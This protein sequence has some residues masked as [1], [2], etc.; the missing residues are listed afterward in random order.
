MRAVAVALGAILVCLLSC[1]SSEVVLLRSVE[2][3]VPLSRGTVA[4]TSN[5]ALFLLTED[6][7]P[8]RMEVPISTAI[9]DSGGDCWSLSTGG[10]LVALRL[11]Y[12]VDLRPTSEPA[13][14][15]VQPG[16]ALLGGNFFRQAD[17][18]VFRWIDQMSKLLEFSVLS[19]ASSCTSELCVVRGDVLDLAISHTDGPPVRFDIGRKVTEVADS[20][21][22][23]NRGGTFY[24][25]AVALRED[26]RVFMVSSRTHYEP[27]VAV[28]EIVGLP[29]IRRLHPGFYEDESHRIWYR[30]V[31]QA[32]WPSELLSNEVPRSACQ[33]YRSPIHEPIDLECV[34]PVEIPALANT[35][36]VLVL[37]DARRATIFAIFPDGTLRCWASEGAAPCPR[38]EE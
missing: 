36:P 14:I 8:S 13:V 33:A 22:V 11:Q 37:D 18:R 29:P 5:G 1:G 28:E 31:V 24:H 6:V 35:R 2:E 17:G 7:I 3:V 26:G 32:G 9:H 21:W 12:G 30:G 16:L 25:G 38:G 15:A 34:D 19:G 27:R 20:A 4:R 23:K 10:E